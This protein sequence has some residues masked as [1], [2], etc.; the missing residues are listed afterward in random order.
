MFFLILIKFENNK[1]RSLNGVLILLI[2]CQF[3]E[4]GKFYYL[5]LFSKLNPITEFIGLR[6]PRPI[7]TSIF[8]MLF[9]V[10]LVDLVNKKLVKIKTIYILFHYLLLY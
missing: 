4:L 8:A 3:V 5:D 2:I 1:V 10:N 9:L 6:F 7:T